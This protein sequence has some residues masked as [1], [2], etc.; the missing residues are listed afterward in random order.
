MKK[1]R[2]LLAC[3]LGVGLLF[4]ALLIRSE[5]QPSGIVAPQLHARDVAQM[6]RAVRQATWKWFWQALSRRDFRACG[7]ELGVFT[8]SRYTEFGLFE[9]NLITGD[10]SQPAGYVKVEVT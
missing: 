7:N 6:R 1:R 9:K 4:V 8:N 5:F 2:L 3:A 10:P